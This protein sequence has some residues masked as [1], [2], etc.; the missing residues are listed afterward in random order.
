MLIPARVEDEAGAIQPARDVLGINGDF[1]RV[2][3][4]SF[5]HSRLGNRSD[6]ANR[7]ISLAFPYRFVDRSCSRARYWVFRYNE[8]VGLSHRYPNAVDLGHNSSVA[9]LY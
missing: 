4:D 2:H 1:L 8:N 3:D 5:K 6:F 9:L 7:P